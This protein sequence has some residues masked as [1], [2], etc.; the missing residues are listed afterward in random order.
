MAQTSLT[1]EQAY[2][3]IKKSHA[4]HQV[5]VP[6]AENTAF[7]CPHC[8]VFADHLW[9]V[10]G[11]LTVLPNTSATGAARWFTKETTGVL[12]AAKCLSCKKEVVFFDGKVIVPASSTAPEPATDMPQEVVADFE[13]ARQIASA[14]PRGAAALLRLVIQKL[15]PILG[16]DKSS[17]DAAI[18][19]LV[20]KKVVDERL[21]RALDTVR[22]VGNE[23]VHPGSLALK[24]DAATAIM[25][26]R[27][28]NFIVEQAI[29]QPK[30]FDALYQGLPSG[31][32]D[33]IVNR[34]KPKA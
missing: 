16:S 12:S 5:A 19:E 13:E 18:A 6:V 2:A 17:I 28:V 10:V 24:D 23:A 32:L 9:G 11:S 33:G 4:S 34:D 31:K 15:M 3:L 8:H 27:L 29:T 22:V 20:A 7:L 1:A 26:F 14:S 30:E 25:L 21:Q